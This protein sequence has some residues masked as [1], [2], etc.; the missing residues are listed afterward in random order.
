MEATNDDSTAGH[1]ATNN[2]GIAAMYQVLRSGDESRGGVTVDNQ[3]M[4][5]VGRIFT[6]RVESVESV[7]VYGPMGSSSLL[8]RTCFSSMFGNDEKART[9]K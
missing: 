6:L 8:Y 2:K 1:F 7:D 4:K 3:Q 5:E 9:S